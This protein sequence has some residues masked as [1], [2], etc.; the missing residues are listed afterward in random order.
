MS[1]SVEV[2]TK[3]LS[4]PGIHRNQRL[5]N[6]LKYLTAAQ[7]PAVPNNG[8]GSRSDSVNDRPSKI[9]RLPPEGSH[10]PFLAEASENVCHVEEQMGKS[11]S[12]HLWGG[13]SAEIQP[14]AELICAAQYFDVNPSHSPILSAEKLFGGSHQGR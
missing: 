9:L 6:I 14:C 1:L 10:Q 12:H 5:C 7:M 3:Q 8:W 2:R 13:E 11:F 4:S